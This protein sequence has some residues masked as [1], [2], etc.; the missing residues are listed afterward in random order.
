MKN[1]LFTFATL[2]LCTSLYAQTIRRVN[3]NAGVTGVNVY[4]TIQ[5]AHDA[6]SNGDIIYVE[7]S[8]AYYGDLIATKKI[9]IIGNGYLLPENQST[10]NIFNTQSTKVGNITFKNG[11][12]NSKLL[13]VS[14]EGGI[15]IL[16]PNITIDRCTS[17][18]GLQIDFDYTNL[19]T[20]PI[21][22]GNNTVITRCF[23]FSYVA[24]Q[25]RT[26]FANP[27]ITLTPNNTY[28][29]N[30]LFGGNVIL[31][32]STITNCIV[33]ALASHNLINCTANNNIYRAGSF[34]Q[35]P[36]GAISNNYSNGNIFPAGNGNVN[37][38]NWAS[39]FIVNSP[40]L[41]KDYQLNPSGPVTNAGIFNGNSPYVLSGLPPY[42]I[43][44]NLTT[45]GSG[46]ASTPLQVSITVRGN[47]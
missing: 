21:S 5:A 43:T 22:T 17:N 30:C 33:N 3:N 27:T 32:N 13:S 15:L 40:G 18:G 8:N 14:I 9:T 45:S 36:T 25:E 1:F 26:F 10:T 38:V 42:P 6:A 44:T 2:C 47:N 19:N 23:G 28:I 20:L 24:V 31:T 7:P 35:T 4:T 46:N 34:N 29:S 16:A 37:N 39:I 12:A 11:S 41:D